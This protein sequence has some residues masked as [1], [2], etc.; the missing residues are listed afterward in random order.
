MVKNLVKENAK[1]KKSY[2]MGSGNVYMWHDHMCWNYTLITTYLLIGCCI[3]ISCNVVATHNQMQLVKKS[4]MIDY[5]RIYDVH[6]TLN[7]GP[8]CN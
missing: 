7:K 8:I 6:V 4:N 1:Q 3:Y 2:V 5:V